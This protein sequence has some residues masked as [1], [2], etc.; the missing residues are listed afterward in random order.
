MRG[1]QRTAEAA[2]PPGPLPDL[3]AGLNAGGQEDNGFLARFLV[4]NTVQDEQ[5]GSVNPVILEEAEAIFSGHGGRP[6]RFIRE[7]TKALQLPYQGAKTWE[8]SKLGSGGRVHRKK[9]GQP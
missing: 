2:H 9:M 8:C 1:D 6:L 7:Y 4:G 3:D 5:R